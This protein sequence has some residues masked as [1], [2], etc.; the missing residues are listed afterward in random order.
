LTLFSPVHLGGRKEH[1]LIILWA[2]RDSEGDILLITTFAFVVWVGIIY[3]K[4]L[5]LKNK[6]KLPECNHKF[7]IL[8]QITTI[9]MQ[10]EKPLSSGIIFTAVTI[11]EV[12][13]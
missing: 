13:F 7:G 2:S 4:T 11:K 10:D 12:T 6:I 9:T 1:R 5:M 8:I 3:C